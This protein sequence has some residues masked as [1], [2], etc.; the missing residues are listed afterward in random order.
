MSNLNSPFATQLFSL[1]IHCI[2][3]TISFLFLCIFGTTLTC[4]VLFPFIPGFLTLCLPAFQQSSCFWPLHIFRGVRCLNPGTGFRLRLSAASRVGGWFHT[5][6]IWHSCSYIPIWHS[7]FSQQ[8]EMVGIWLVAHGNSLIL[9]VTF[10]PVC[11]ISYS[12]QHAEVC[13]C[14]CWIIAYLTPFLLLI[15]FILRP[16]LPF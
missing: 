8:Y 14:P 16:S 2:W 11:T 4:P 9:H 7:S 6:C 3:K 10:Y 1:F 15:K 5:S 12:N 13:L